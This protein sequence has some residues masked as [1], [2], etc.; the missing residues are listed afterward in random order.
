MI[1]LT[2]GTPDQSAAK[3]D[4]SIAPDS[5][6]QQYT[7]SLSTLIS[8]Q[9]STAT[10]AS[11][12]PSP[13]L[14]RIIGPGTFYTSALAQQ[15]GQPAAATASSLPSLGSTTDHQLLLN[16]ASNAQL[17]RAYAQEPHLFTTTQAELEETGGIP[18]NVAQPVVEEKKLAEKII[19]EMPDLEIEAVEPEVKKP[20]FWTYKGNGGLQFTQSYV[21]KN[22]YKGG[23]NSYSM[24]T[25]LTF[26]ANFNNQ[27]KVQLNNKFEAR[28]GFQ[29]TETNVPKFRPTDNLLRFTSNFGIKAIGNWNYAAQ[30]QLQTQPYRGYQGSTT[31]VISDF[32]SPLYVRSSIGMDYNIKKKRFTGTLKLAPLS[33]V[34]T[35]VHVD[36]RVER[37]GI[38]KGHNSKHE[39]GPNIQF[40]FDYKMTKDISWHSRLY[41]FSNFKST[42]IENE[43][44]INFTINKY[45]SAKLFLYPRFEDT[46][47]YGLDYAKD[48]EG[49]TTTE[50]SDDSAKR[51]HWMFQ[52]YLSLGINYDF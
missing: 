37:Y 42:L 20:N 22:W 29:A 10:S 16:E 1:F 44:T 49:N 51:T 35:Y 46:K 7:D 36:S 24:L 43:H 23:L 27:R 21:S 5:V 52:E 4:T 45:L 34:I 18:A 14:F 13:Y 38:E 41:W 6:V 28:L 9:A 30:L 2:L 26:E 17:A 19:E 31:T 32:L 11:T 47:Y 33:Y 12:T 3:P 40:T 15:L 25:M 39:W 48:E 8:S 50:L